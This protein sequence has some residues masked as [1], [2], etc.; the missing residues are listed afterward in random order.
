MQQVGNWI[1]SATRSLVDSP[2]Q[3][4]VSLAHQGTHTKDLASASAPHR[5]PASS[6]QRDW[7]CPAMVTRSRMVRVWLGSHFSWIPSGI[8]KRD[9]TLI[10]EHQVGCCGHRGE[11]RLGRAF[12][13]P[14]TVSKTVTMGTRSVRS[15]G[16]E[17]DIGNS[18][19]VL[20]RFGRQI[21]LLVPGA[22]EK[23]MQGPV[24]VL[25]HRDG[26]SGTPSSSSRRQNRFA[27]RALP[28]CPGSPSLC[29]A[30]QSAP[31]SSEIQCAENSAPPR[32]PCEHSSLR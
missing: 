11:D 8:L 9:S 6:R 5:T 21:V 24:A 29:P 19:G 23:R 3:V 27:V 20:H 31:L 30:S 4:G 13:H 7:R 15:A 25:K 32:L 28:A 17:F 26:D 2:D 18:Q 10:G 22:A 12:I 16:C 14:R 1:T